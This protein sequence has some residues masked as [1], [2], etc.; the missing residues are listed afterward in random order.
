LNRVVVTPILRASLDVA[1]ALVGETA[2]FYGERLGLPT[3]LDAGGAHVE[4]G[5]SA[6]SFHARPGEPFYHVALLVPGDRFDAALAWA[7][8]RVEL[9]PER[10]SG[11]V[12]FDFAF[13]DALACY[14]HD[15]SGTIVELIAHRG[16][17]ESRATGAFRAQ[18]LLGLSEIGIVGDP[19]A[20]AAVLERELGLEVWDGTVEGQR[21]LAFV[22]EQARTLILCRAGRP[23]LPTG[24]PAEPWPV[25]VVVAGEPAGEVAVGSASLVRRAGSTA[26]QA[27]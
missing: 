23:W 25:E 17:G 14:F 15:P 7:E 10:E 4:L 8:E 12:V 27:S 6:L 3:T 5:E 1:D 11:E 24:R 2:A 13:W 22:G 26:V 9:L 21:S 20:D 18:E 16:R 19:P